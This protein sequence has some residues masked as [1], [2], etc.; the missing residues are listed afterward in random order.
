MKLFLL[1]VFVFTAACLTLRTHEDAFWNSYATQ[2]TARNA[3]QTGMVFKKSS[4]LLLGQ[5]GVHI[6]V[7]VTQQKAV[8]EF[9]KAKGAIKSLTLGSTTYSL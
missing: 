4:G 9:V 8:A 7:T 2:F 1:T 5:T 6:S 3:S